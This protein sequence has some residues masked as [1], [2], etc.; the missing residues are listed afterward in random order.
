M[1][2]NF[3][4]VTGDETC[5]SLVNVETEETKH[6]MHTYSPNKPRKFK[7]TNACQKADG[8]YFWDRKGVLKV[9]SC[10][11]G[12]QQR[13]NC[14]GYETIKNTLQAYSEQKSV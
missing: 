5:V 3:S 11:K 13:Q 7:Q 12:P 8:A 14:I 4:R 2:M 1:A 10:N 9:N 6:W